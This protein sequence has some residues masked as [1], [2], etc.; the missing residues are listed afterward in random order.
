ML[1]LIV[2]F[3]IFCAIG[4][5][6]EFT[7]GKETAWAVIYGTKLFEFIYVLLTINLIGNIFKYKM[8]RIKKLSIALFHIGFVAVLLGASIT[9]YTGY[10]GVMHIKEGETTNIIKTYE[11]YIQIKAQKGK[12]T[13][14]CEFKKNISKISPNAFLVKLKIDNKYAFLIYEDYLSN[15]KLVINLSYDGENKEIELS[16][17]NTDVQIS[18]VNFTLTWGPKL[19][20]LPFYLKLIDFKLDKFEGTMSPSSQFS[21]F[22]LIDKKEQVDTP[23]TIYTNHIFDYK[24]HR[25]FQS[26]YDTNEKGT[27]IIVNK[28]FGKYPTYIGYFLLLFGFINN[29]IDPKSRFRKLA[30]EIQQNSTVKNTVLMLISIVVLNSPLYAYGAIDK[31][32]ASKFGDILVQ[33]N[34][35]RI[36]SINTFSHQL[37]LKLSKKSSINNLDPTQI[38]LGMMTNPEYWKSVKMIQVKHR[39][40]SNILGLGENDKTYASFRDFFDYTQ[41]TSYKLATYIKHSRSKGLSQRDEFDKQIIKVDEKVNIAIMI[42]TDTI[43]NIIPKTNDAYKRWY[44][45]KDAILNFESKDSKIVRELFSNYFNEIEYAKNTKNWDKADEAL[46]HIKNYQKKVSKNK[47][48]SQLQ[49]DIERLFIQI[50]LFDKLIF[51]YLLSGIVL[52]SLIIIKLLKSNINININKLS[53][54]ILYIIGIAFT[55]HTIGMG[56]TWYIGEHVPWTSI[57]EVMI[58]AAWSMVGLGILFVRYSLMAPALTSIMAGIALGV[59][60][61][62]SME[63]EITY[64][65]PTMKSYLLNFHISLITASF[66]FLSFSMILGIFTLLLFIFKNKNYTSINRSIIEAT[67]INEMTTILGLFMLVIS[68]FLGAVWA[69]ELW[70]RYWGW[71]PKETWVLIS[72]LAYAMIIHFRF[73]PFFK[74]NYEYSFS[75]ASI[76]AYTTVIMAIFGVNYFISGLHSYASDAPVMIPKYL[77]FIIVAIVIVIV[78]SFPKR[79][80]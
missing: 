47:I 9:R 73:V 34:H 46:Q 40:I 6:L 55:M 23:F 49:I 66:G 39:K 36:K 29:L 56:I 10:I 64:I 30:L 62:T 45:I 75:V 42:Y 48:P 51:V 16:S 63:P 41:P 18:D 5:F 38:M 17:L 76:V 65:V 67:K 59:T 14:S 57:Y 15:K 74:E 28:D 78:Y 21:Q 68:N 52:L 80:L 69:N 22:I 13:Y 77:Y 37:I 54:I 79:K 44:S 1:V 43:M 33:A 31:E 53:K 3:S 58:F 71:D 7:Y 32:H 25:F 61:L 2:I 4:T 60:I 8:L 12:K 24:N 27:S 11:N 50:S 72:I 19:I 26:T 35:S 70:G 20:S